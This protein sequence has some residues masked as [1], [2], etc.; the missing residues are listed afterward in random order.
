[1]MLTLPLKISAGV[2]IKPAQPAAAPWKAPASM[3]GMLDD[4]SEAPRRIE[5]WARTTLGVLG[6]WTSGA[7]CARRLRTGLVDD[8]GQHLS[9]RR[10]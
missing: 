8:A 1:M 6:Y 2:L 7:F 4:V 9:S 3:K 5:H 10:R